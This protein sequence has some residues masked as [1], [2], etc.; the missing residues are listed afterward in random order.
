MERRQ[1]KERE[2]KAGK[3]ELNRESERQREEVE[4]ARGFSKVRGERPLLAGFCDSLGHFEYSPG[5][6]EIP[7][8]LASPN[9]LFPWSRFVLRENLGREGVSENV[10]SRL[11]PA[12]PRPSLSLSFSFCL[13]RAR[14]K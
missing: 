13:A 14:S 9:R 2:G 10:G 4:E 5:S 1:G 3:E 7:R 12:I 6:V 8:I 11:E